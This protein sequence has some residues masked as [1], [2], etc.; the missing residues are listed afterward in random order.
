MGEKGPNLI[1]KKRKL[2]HGFKFGGLAYKVKLLYH[3]RTR[4]G[5]PRAHTK[6]SLGVVAICIEV[7]RMESRSKLASQTSPNL[8]WYSKKADLNI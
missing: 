4:V 8:P 3:M 1:A 5:I 7:L 6:N 2:K